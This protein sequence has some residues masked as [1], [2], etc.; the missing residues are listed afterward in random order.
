MKMQSLLRKGYYAL[1]VSWRAQAKH[2]VLQAMGHRPYR[3]RTQ[4]TT[5]YSAGIPGLVSVIL[6]VY[7]GERWVELAAQS[8]L[9]QEYHDIELLIVDDGSTDGTESILRQIAASDERCLCVRQDHRGLGAALTVGHRLA[10]GHISTWTSADNRMGTRSLALLV[11]ALVERPDVVLVYSDYRLINEQGMPVLGGAFRSQ[12]RDAND[13]SIVRVPQSAN[14]L[15][16]GD[17]FIGA[18]FAYR[19]WAQRLLG[20]WSDAL[21]VEDY[22]FWLR[23]YRLGTFAYVRGDQDMYCYRLHSDT[24]SARSQELRIRDKLERVLETGAIPEAAVA[25]AVQM[26]DNLESV[27]SVWQESLTGN[28][29]DTTLVVTTA[30]EWHGAVPPS[31]RSDSVMGSAQDVTRAVKDVRAEGGR[32]EVR[33]ISGKE[34]M[35]VGVQVNGDSS[36]GGL[37][38]F[39]ASLAKA[40]AVH[41]DIEWLPADRPVDVVLNHNQSYKGQGP[42]V[43]VL[44]NSYAWIKPWQRR[45]FVE[46]L[47]RSRAIV[48][49]SPEVAAYS[50]RYFDIEPERV[51]VLLNGVDLARLR[52]RPQRSAARKALGLPLDDW[53]WLQV[54]SIFPPKGQLLSSKVV[55]DNSGERLV[56][57]GPALDHAYFRAALT[58][59]G[60]R[61][62]HYPYREDMATVYAA[63]DALLHPSVTEGWSL[64]LGEAIFCGLPVVATKVGGAAEL[65]GCTGAGVLVE[66]LVPVLEIT[67]QS[68]DEVCLRHAEKLAPALRRAMDVAR[69]QDWSGTRPSAARFVEDVHSMQATARRYDLFLRRLLR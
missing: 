16:L 25:P 66:P 44:H 21:G 6:P 13:P 60:D 3:A 28:A 31:R 7:N 32:W 15:A 26:V 43:E 29:H 33:Q 30:P 1:P 42:F 65:I 52:R 27:E 14:G 62:V 11:Q 12:W 51:T 34:R 54:G 58:A 67:P 23:M 59:G 45:P 46:R 39:A 22:E 48:A 35:V 5:E 19:T 20:S 56:L 37:E 18:S 17:N 4:L 50:I 47:S 64:V 53:I 2:L 40:L 61:V 9:D 41:A 24:L 38:R 63:A 49:V 55:S 36:A 8:V 57:V 68:F 10:R 69:R